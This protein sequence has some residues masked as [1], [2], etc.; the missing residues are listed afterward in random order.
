MSYDINKLSDPATL[1]AI[2][3]KGKRLVKIETEGPE[4]EPLAVVISLDKAR[5]EYQL[6]R[7]ATHAGELT[8]DGNENFIKSLM[9]WPE[10]A[11]FDA[12]LEE[13]PALA[14]ELAPE[15]MKYM[16]LMRKARSGKF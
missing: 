4:G 9:V 6:Q 11:D 15:V 1:S 7:A 13:Y 5:A 10:R 14:E 8:A 16:G 12:L 2:R 3:A